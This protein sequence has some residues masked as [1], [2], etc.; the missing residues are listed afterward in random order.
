MDNLNTESNNTIIW[1]YPKTYS[2]PINKKMPDQYITIDSN[3]I[4]VTN[5]TDISGKKHLIFTIP[6][7]IDG[8]LWDNHYHFGERNIEKTIKTLHGKNKKIYIDVIFF[9]KT[10]QNP[11]LNR[12][13]LKNCY[14]NFNEK[15]RNVE[16]IICLQNSTIKKM[17]DYFSIYGEDLKIIK[18][19]ISRP[20]LGIKIGGI[21]RKTIKNKKRKI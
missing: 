12:K 17:S 16:D 3:R 10:I 14:Y 4:Y 18:E 8:K 7:L 2:G 21:K 19:I 6:E 9:H 15:I 5:Y 1:Y 13:E 20:F 11:L